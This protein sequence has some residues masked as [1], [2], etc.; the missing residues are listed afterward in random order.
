MSITL[1]HARLL[2]AQHG[3]SGEEIGMLTETFR[4]DGVRRDCVL[5]NIGVT[6]YAF[7]RLQRAL[8]P[9][10]LQAPEDTCGV[11]AS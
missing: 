6:F 4:R 10:E 1:E 11:A 3:V 7:N 2:V 8:L 5:K 9:K